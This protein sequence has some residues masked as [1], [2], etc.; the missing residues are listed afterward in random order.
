M[1]K[2]HTSLFSLKDLDLK[3]K[4]VFVRLDLNVPLEKEG[5]EQWI[6]SDDNRIREAIPTLEYLIEQGAKIIIGSHLGRPKGEKNSAFSLEPVATHLAQLLEKEVLLA[7]DCIGEGIELMVTQLAPRQILM[8]ENLRF[9]KEETEN[10]TRFVHKLARLGEVYVT[11][12]FG[13]CHRKH[14]STYGLP[15]AMA[16]K[17]YGFLIEKELQYLQPLLHQPKKPFYAILGGSKVSDKIKMIESL[18]VHLDGLLIGGAMAHAFWKAKDKDLPEKAKQPTSEDIEAA[19]QVI[20]QAKKKGIPLII[21]RDTIDG[22]DIGEKTIREFC[23]ELKNAKTVFWNGPLGWFEKEEYA[24][25]TFEVAKFLSEHDGIKIVGGGD[26]VSAI[27]SAGLSQKFTHLST[28]GG[29]VL[30][31]LESGKL[32]GIE[33]LRNYSTVARRDILTY[34]E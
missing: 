14:A 26:T 33:I 9:Y 8:L 6:V 2:D 11:D 21:P 16:H 20:F 34:E 19:H 4:K 15:E 32:P 30:E 18:M 27:R 31:F 23:D 29:A 5:E 7:D 24:K 22:F 3:N 28:G 17:G 1:T 25:G 10:E 12:A 13:T